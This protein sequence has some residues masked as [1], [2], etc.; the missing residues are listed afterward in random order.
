[1]MF[2]EII[3]PFPEKYYF[4]AE[5]KITNDNIYK[6]LNFIFKHDE[7]IDIR[8]I[9]SQ[10]LNKPIICEND[11]II[12]IW[13]RPFKECIYMLYKHLEY[14]MDKKIQK[15]ID[16]EYEYIAT[17]TV[18]IDYPSDDDDFLPLNIR[19]YEERAKAEKIL[20]VIDSLIDKK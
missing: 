11:M 7:N 10:Y 5:K 1:M 18:I 15:T 17:K 8:K 12:D 3:D 9:C 2:K 14:E 4:M 6:L 19:D 16:K 20:N 13:P